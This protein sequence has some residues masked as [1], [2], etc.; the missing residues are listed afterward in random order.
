MRWKSLLPSGQYRL[1]RDHDMDVV[2]AVSF[3]HGTIANGGFQTNSVFTSSFLD[4]G[5]GGPSP[6]LV[7]VL[8]R[9][10]DGRQVPIRV[11]LNLALN[12]SRE[13]I[14]IQPNDVVLL[15]ETPDE[16]TTRYATKA[17]KFFGEWTIWDRAESV[18]VGS[19]LVP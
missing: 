9:T 6:S 16:A 15:Q 12:D 17:L 19:M 8:R 11:D 10:P 1:P 3:V 5:I 13:R 7:I 2:E 18:G 14:L 4:S